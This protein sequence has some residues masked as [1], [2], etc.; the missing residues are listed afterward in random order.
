LPLQPFSPRGVFSIASVRVLRSETVV[1]QAAE[2]A[3]QILIKEL[4]KEF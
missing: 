3:V 4:I 1:K 2:N